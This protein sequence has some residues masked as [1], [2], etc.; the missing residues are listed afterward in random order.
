VA[1]T[2]GRGDPAAVARAWVAGAPGNGFATALATLNA[3]E[4]R[5]V[6]RQLLG[7]EAPTEAS[8]HEEGQKP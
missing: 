2:G 8:I 5:E 3:G 6:T 1:A 4:W 7:A